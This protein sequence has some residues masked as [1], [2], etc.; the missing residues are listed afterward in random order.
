MATDSP[1]APVDPANPDAAV[2][3]NAPARREPTAADRRS[4]ALLNQIRRPAGFGRNAP[5]VAGTVVGVLAAISLLS[6][7]IPAFRRLIHDPRRYVDDYIITLPD[8]SFAW[9]F[10]LALIAIALSAR[11][12]IAWWISVIYLVLFI[13]GNLVFLI[14]ALE[15]DLEVTSWDR[16]NLWIGVVIDLAALIFLIATYKQF[17]TRVRRGAVPAAIAT[18]IVGLGIATLLGWA[19]V[20]AFP[21]NLTHGER[22]AYAFNRV[23]AFGAIDADASFD[24]RHAPVFVNGLL[25]LFGAL[26]LIAAAAVLFRSQRLRWLITAEDE[27][28]IRALIKRFN[29]DDSLAYFSTRRDKAVVF[30][31]DG[32]A[33]ITYRVEVGVGMAGGDPIGDPESWPDAIAEFVA[34]C[35]KYGWHPAAIGASAHGAEAYHAAGFVTLNIGDEAIIHTREY[36]LSGPAMKAVRQAVTRTRRAGVTVRIRRH[37]DIDD[38]EMQ[39]VIARADEWRDTDEERGFAMALSRLGDRADDE[40]LLVEAVIDEGTPSERVVGMLSFVPWGRRGASLDLMR[41]D[42]SGPNGV[43]ETMVSE[44]CRNS[45]QFGITEVSLNFAAFRAFFEQGPQI[46]AGPIMRFGY[47][48]LMFGSK[49][50]QMESLY[51]SNAKYLPDW[52]PRYLCFEDSR[53]LP[54]V[55]L[56]AIVT[57]GFV[58]LPKFG[59][60]KHYEGGR[61]SIPP[62]VDAPALIARLEEEAETRDVAVVHRPEQ[63]RVRLEKMDRLVEQGFDPYPP[64]DAPTHTIAQARSEPEGTVVTIAGRVT[65]LRDFGKVVFADVHDWSGEVQVLVEESRL[66]PGTPDFGGDV[67]LGDLIQ[68]RGVVGTSRSGELSILIDA[69]RFNGKCLRPLPDKWAGLTDPEARVRQRYVDLAINERSRQLLATR[70]IVVK[71][72]RDFLSARGF[73]EVETPILQ[74]IHGGANATPFQTHINAYNLDLYL[75]IAPEL[76]LKRLCVGGVEKVF[77]IGRNFR[78][79]GV[80]FSHNPEFTSLEAYEAHSDYLKMLDL[81]REMIQHAATAAYGEPVI[82]RTDADGNEERID[83]SGEWPVKTV[84]EVVSEGAGEEITPDTPVEQL[85]AVCDRLDINYRPDWDAGQIV[86]ELYEHLGEDRTTFPTFYTDFPTSVSPLTRAHRSKPGVAER[87]D[88]VAW[89]VELGTAYTELTDPVEQRKRLTEQ[90]ILAADGD[91]EA[92]ELD[93]DFLQALEYAMPPTGGLGVGVDRVVMLITGQS[94]RESLAFPLAKPQDA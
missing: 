57:E 32:R 81:T 47:S 86:L 18:L 56:A 28:L 50:F 79:E 80:D 8:T 55:G 43:V 76:Y 62:G 89:G 42:R 20:W 16:T 41:R 26:A 4:L 68:A 40:C 67:D 15:D 39:K 54:R 13:A 14:P 82:V 66:I 75:R 58:T 71:S 61:S 35:E 23:V 53:I 85:R 33:A 30:S 24:G 83:I 34:L 49:F 45:E 3:G 72:L 46:G 73:L 37:A 90:S 2:P 51:K 77:E 1:L 21:H 10:V 44:L 27:S 93:E 38:A 65:R 87:W 22:L 11:K 69:W 19:L 31:P 91:P 88:L 9:A 84:H 74:Q 63:V 92:M 36:S 12:R 70:S 94:I 48:V 17:Y 60:D 64:A 29:D 25:G 78:N 59:R 52:Q 7:L 5:K 6:S